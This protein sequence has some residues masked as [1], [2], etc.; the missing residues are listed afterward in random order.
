MVI[1][2]FSVNNWLI[3]S[4]MSSLRNAV[5]RIAHKERSQPIARKK[6]GLLEK[7]KDYSIRAQDYKKKKQTINSLRQKAAFKNEDEFYFKMIS[8]KTKVRIFMS[9]SLSL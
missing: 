3:K 9:T 8:S 5:K 1:P 7:H 6:L 4:R 2:K